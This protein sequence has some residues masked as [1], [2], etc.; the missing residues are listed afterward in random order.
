MP[1]PLSGD[2]E[3]IEDPGSWDIITRDTLLIAIGPGPLLI[4]SIPLNKLPIGIIT[5]SR[6]FNWGKKNPKV[7]EVFSHYDD[8]KLAPAKTKGLDYPHIGPGA[9]TILLLRKG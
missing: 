4:A 2:L 9:A 7:A 1:F 3:L 6:T 8:I 5:D